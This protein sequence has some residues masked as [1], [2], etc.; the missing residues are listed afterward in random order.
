M[1]RISLICITLHRVDEP[2]PDLVLRFLPP[3]LMGL[4]RKGGEVMLMQ[5]WI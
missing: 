5:A 3:G 4:G 2:G 1:W